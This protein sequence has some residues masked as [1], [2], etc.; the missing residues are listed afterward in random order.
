MIKD[1]KANTS[2]KTGLWAYGEIFQ[3][4][5]TFWGFFPIIGKNEKNFSNHWK[6]R[7]APQR[8]VPCFPVAYVCNLFMATASDIFFLMVNNR[9]FYK[10][11]IDT[12]LDGI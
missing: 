2:T 11:T 9:I 3:S 7:H 6:N 8:D 4:L 1:S 5:E 10:N 12:K